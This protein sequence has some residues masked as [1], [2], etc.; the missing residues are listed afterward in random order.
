MV[1]VY[2]GN[3]HEAQL[4]TATAA[5]IEQLSDALHRAAGE[6]WLVCKDPQGAV[7]GQFKVHD[8]IGY[9]IQTTDVQAHGK[10]VEARS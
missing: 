9:A 1:T 6:L 7:V 5:A 4:Q 10:R 2:F 3:G 8:I